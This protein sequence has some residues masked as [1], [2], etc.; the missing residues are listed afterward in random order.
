MVENEQ[1]LEL[2]RRHLSEMHLAAK[3]LSHHFYYGYPMDEFKH[4]E[5]IQCNFSVSFA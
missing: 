5:G 2:E 1:A 3:P 4:P